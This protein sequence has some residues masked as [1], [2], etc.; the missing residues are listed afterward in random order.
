MLSPN[1]VDR[2]S[3][4]PPGGAVNAG[5]RK[6]K[7]YSCHE[8]RRRK[9]RCD[10][11][12]PSCNRCQR[13]GQ[14]DAC[15]YDGPPPKR[16]PSETP[17]R[18]A[19]R[20]P[21]VMPEAST[22][23]VHRPRIGP[24][25]SAGRLS[26]NL[27]AERNNGTWQLLSARSAPVFQYENERPH[28]KDDNEEPV[29]ESNRQD[30]IRTVIFRGENFRTQY[31]GGSNPASLI[32]H[33]PELRYFMKDA[34]RNHKS[35]YRVQHDLKNR[36]KKWK[37]EKI[38]TLSTPQLDFTYLLPS[39]KT[40]DELVHLYLDNFEPIYRIIHIPSFWNEYVKFSS[41]HQSTSSA[42]VVT[43]LLIMAAASCIVRNDQIRYMGDSSLARERAVMWIEASE[44]W[45]RSHSQ[46]NIYLA[47]WQIRCLSILAK[48]VNTV[49]KKRHWT[50]AGTLVRE[51]MAAGF[52]RDPCL[53]GERISAFDREM[54]R[55]MWATMTEL[56][57]QASTDRGMTSTSA[58][59][60]SDTKGVLN[61]EDKDLTDEPVEL[62]NQ[63]PITEYTTSSFLSF[64]NAS[65]SLRVTL[66]TVVNDI[67]S[68]VK[69]EEVMHY[70]ELI[71]KALQELPSW[72]SIQ[73][74]SNSGSLSLLARSLLDIQLRQY[75]IMLHGPFARQSESTSRHSLSRM[76][77]FEAAAS[78]ID[79]HKR[80][81]E[82]HTSALLLLRHDYFRAALVICQNSLISISLRNDV[83]LSSNTPIFFEY[84][85][86]ALAL[87]EDRIVQLG[88]G[89]THH[90]YISAGRA[91]LSLTCSPE[92]STQEGEQ[93]VDRVARQ[94]YRVMASQVDIELAK[95]KIM[96]LPDNGENATYD[97]SRSPNDLMDNFN[98]SLDDPNAL[99][100][101]SLFEH[102]MDNF[103]GDPE[104]WV[105]DSLYPMGV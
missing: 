24:S 25:I 100:V 47:V 50:E 42:F 60:F 78:I 19:A 96:T 14:A 3:N 104:V 71:T 4:S 105:F 92:Q 20:T 29:L 6:R 37:L 75:L 28:V 95:E 34:I 56:E 59:I 87:L 52:H 22:H 101:N 61:I 30:S 38:N 88:T 68:S 53:L 86:K 82:T 7:V 81:N 46:K 94:Y 67:S 11:G 23:E 83:L 16:A 35:L 97:Q 36:H 93:A 48:L 32:G 26:S 12:Y 39:Q 55:R 80:L 45:L 72:E 65:F 41:D 62:V 90:W 8:C 40:I 17:T 33:F 10:R 51:A 63:R 44:S 102:G 66:N 18:L 103:F 89:Y 2:D 43:I 1:A 99:D 54:R 27:E 84:I 73:S 9:L 5:K 76:I 74:P 79:Q 58:G 21:V 98:S 57:L 70:E 15:I 69:Y 85:E 64:S 13:T 49:K 91:L 31:F 77:C